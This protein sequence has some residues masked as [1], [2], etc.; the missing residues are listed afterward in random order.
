MRGLVENVRE[1]RDERMAAVFR[2]E[3]ERN[4]EK[5]DIA[6]NMHEFNLKLKSLDS[7]TLW[8]EQ[9]KKRKELEKDPL[10]RIQSKVSA[11]KSR[12]NELKTLASVG[13]ERIEECELEESEES[14]GDGEQVGEDEL[15]VS[16][17]EERASIRM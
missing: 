17:E 12:V 4:K 11:F 14:R 8:T 15:L 13:T 9:S 16:K 5:Q 10:L 2:E 7:L 6:V 1:S 3:E